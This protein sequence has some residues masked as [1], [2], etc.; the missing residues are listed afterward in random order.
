MQ[1]LNARLEL[2]PAE[3]IVRWAHGVFGRRVALL[4]A[5]QQAGC[6]VC[7]MIAELGFQQ[8]IDVLFVDTGVNFRETYWTI[9]RLREEYKLNIIALHPSRTMAEQTRDEGVLYLSKQ[10]Q[11]RC[12]TLRKKEP[13]KH[14]IGRYDAMIG[15][16]RRGEGGRRKNIPVLALDTELNMLRVHPLLAMSREELEARIVEKNIIVNPLHAQGYP[17]ISCDRCT[18]PVLPN[19]HERAGRWRHLEGATEY[20]AINPTDRDKSEDEPD[21]IQLEEETVQRLLAPF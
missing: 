9:D 15:S 11:Q 21:F 6:V 12:C 4:S 19:E 2:L 18:T 7:Q 17:T 13:L 8:D 14:V 5:M 16:L 1:G 20:C 10:G 3:E